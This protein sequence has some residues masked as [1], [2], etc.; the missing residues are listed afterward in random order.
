MDKLTSALEYVEWLELHNRE[1]YPVIGHDG[2]KSI[3][4]IKI[5]RDFAEV[6]SEE[7]AQIGK[8]PNERTLD[9]M[10]APWESSARGLMFDIDNKSSRPILITRFHTVA[11]RG[12]VG[13]CAYTMY[14]TPGQWRV[15][16]CPCNTFAP[17]KYCICCC[18]SCPS[19]RPNFR[20]MK[21]CCRCTPAGNDRAGCCCWGECGEGRE[22]AEPCCE[23]CIPCCT[24]RF[25]FNPILVPCCLPLCSFGCGCCTGEEL[26]GAGSPGI[27]AVPLCRCNGCRCCRDGVHR[28]APSCTV[29][30]IPCNCS[31][32]SHCCHC[33]RKKY[34]DRRRWTRVTSGWVDLP[35]DWGHLGPLP[36]LKDFEGGGI[37]IPP[38]QRVAVYIHSAYPEGPA[39][40]CGLAIRGPFTRE[41]AQGDPVDEVRLLVAF[42][43]RGEG[44]GRERWGGGGQGDCN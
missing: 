23:G 6:R 31:C 43:Y 32:C 30:L 5:E 22:L 44:L 42:V 34:F 36:S 9:C 25:G 14:R 40:D 19:G 35:S 10:S 3:I 17:C 27:P 39:G 1:N 38:R 13:N 28:Q 8:D 26:G 18:G 15:G 21:W 29:C 33:C 7:K 24:G 4:K 11:G 16:R 37:L 2:S 41:Y 20:C 12:K